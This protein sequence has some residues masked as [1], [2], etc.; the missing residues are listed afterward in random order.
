LTLHKIVNNAVIYLKRKGIINIWK[1]F[2]F[3]GTKYQN[4]WKIITSITTNIM[5]K[6]PCINTVGYDD[7]ENGNDPKSR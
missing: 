7:K 3:F 1:A 4:I 2:P 6:F 5:E